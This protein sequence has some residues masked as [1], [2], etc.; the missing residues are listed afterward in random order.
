[1]STVVETISV[2]SHDLDDRI[3]MESMCGSQL[4]DHSINSSFSK[5]LSISSS[6]NEEKN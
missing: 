6:S 3:W 5:I 2:S 4:V 1:M